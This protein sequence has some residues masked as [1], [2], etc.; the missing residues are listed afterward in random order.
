MA[1]LGD[2]IHYGT[3][4]LL[5][6]PLSPAL[7]YLFPARRAYRASH[8]KTRARRASS[9]H[10]SHS[11]G[12]SRG[13][14]RFWGA[15]G[16]FSSLITAFGATNEIVSYSRFSHN[17]DEDADHGGRRGKEEENEDRFWRRHAASDFLSTYE[18]N[19]KKFVT[20]L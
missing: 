10:P 12:S 6:P 8:A 18:N 9:I 5:I 17:S 2:V 16:P 4:Q 1:H 13:R 3:R 11:S 7:A 19:T 20:E 14:G 15:S